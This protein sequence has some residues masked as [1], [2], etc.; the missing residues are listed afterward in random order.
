MIICY[1]KANIKS[2]VTRTAKALM[3]Y[4]WENHRNKTQLNEYAE[5]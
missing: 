3:Q 4:L 1:V 2:S 5:N